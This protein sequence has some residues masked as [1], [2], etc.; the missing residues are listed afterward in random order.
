ME[1]FSATNIQMYVAIGLSLINGV[2]ICF[3]ATK[4]FQMLQLTGYK[5]RG[6]ISWLKDTKA[7]YVSRLTLLSCLSFACMLV[8]NA[9]FSAYSSPE[10]L[11]AY[12]G[13]IFYFYFTV[14]FCV[15]M[16]SAPKKVALKNT[17]R[18]T[19]LNIAL[20]IV[21]VI[22]TFGLIALFS[23]FE[24]LKLIKFAIICILPMLSPFLVPLVHLIMVPLE[25]LI[26]KRYVVQAKNK[27]KKREGDLIKIGITGSFGKT[28]T[29]YILNT[30][31]SQKYKV[32]M[33]PHSFNTITGISKVINN[34]LKPEDEVLISE[35]GA[36]NVGDIKKLASF[37]QPKYGIITA[38]GS[39]HLYSFGS[40]ENIA[41]TKFELIESLPPDGFAVFN[42]ENDG[43]YKL[44]QRC[45]IEKCV[46]GAR[47]DSTLKAAR[48]RVDKS[49]THFSLN[50]DGKTISCNTKLIG[51]HNVE[52]IMVCAAMA[53]KLG[54][55][56]EQIKQGI[57]ELKP[58]P[59]RLEF[60][61]NSNGVI[62]LDDSYNASVEGS[63][64]ALDVLSKFGNKKIVI[65]PGLVE[66]GKLEREANFNFGV[67]LAK[68]AN[69]VIIVN[70]V[71]LE[72][73]KEGIKSTGFDIKNV[74]EAETLDKAKTLLGGVVA[75]G[76]AV[77]FENDLPD[78]YV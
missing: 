70:K 17:A 44:Y 8:I 15:N 21:V 30:I 5:T 72:A 51:K 54:L 46:T 58:V 35:M 49:G 2:L 45:K 1:F 69:I 9:L 25:S 3:A 26:I 62:I 10:G 75:A 74:Y 50:F 36:R 40:L 78:N 11:Y 53:V 56:L 55:S 43:A 42:G 68:V 37:V 23:S 63:E 34:Y 47:A 61:E 39:Q 28:S 16:F 20:Y 67:K 29:K 60:T 73:I 24:S 33:S 57:S 76:D 12:I 32:C 48:I 65:T 13:L 41:N 7:R 6:Y 4:C 22:I 38:V 52:N 19:R 14:V 64:V 27:L 18:M 31:L 77:L 71:N 66:L 59:H